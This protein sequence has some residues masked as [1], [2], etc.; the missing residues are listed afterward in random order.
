[1]FPLTHVWRLREDLLPESAFSQHGIIIE[2]LTDNESTAQG[3][4]VAPIKDD[5]HLPATEHFYVRVT[6]T[7]EAHTS[8]EMNLPENGEILLVNSIPDKLYYSGQ[9]LDGR[10]V[11][12]FPKS[13]VKIED[14]FEPT[15]THCDLN[16]T[17][18]STTSPIPSSNP[19]TIPPPSPPPICKLKDVVGFHS[20]YI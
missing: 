5:T 3:E 10:R 1:M 19:P 20:V 15:E 11:G 8:D 14:N 13:F 17:N 4:Q 12:I 7:M 2:G 18:S 9:S 6:K 16:S